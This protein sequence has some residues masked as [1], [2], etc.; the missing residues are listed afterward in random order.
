M[1]TRVISCMYIFNAPITCPQKVTVEPAAYW[2]AES[3][4]GSDMQ[5][6]CGNRYADASQ[7]CT[8]WAPL[9][10][11]YAVDSRTQLGGL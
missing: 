9:D 11:L 2:M 7:R 10:N 4:I 5:L 3:E 8:R 6:N 1:E